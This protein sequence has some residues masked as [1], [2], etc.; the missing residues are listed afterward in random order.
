MLISDLSIAAFIATLFCSF[1]FLLK[2]HNLSVVPP[3]VLLCVVLV[4]QTL[5]SYI[6]LHPEQLHLKSGAILLESCL[7]FAALLYSAKFCRPDGFAGLS[8]TSQIL[9]P[10]ALLFALSG[11]WLRSVPLFFSPDFGDEKVLFLTNTGFT[12][13]LLLSVFLVLSMM[14]LERTLSAL[15]Q[16]ERWRVKCEI[17]AFCVLLGTHVV[18]FSQAFLYRSLD[19]RLLDVRSFALLLTVVLLFYSRV[20]RSRGVEISISRGVAYRS[21]ILF[22]VGV[23]ILGLGLLGEGLEYISFPMQRTFLLVVAMV[24]A[25]VLSLLFLSENV[26]RKVKAVVHRNFFQSKFDYRVHWLAFTDR[27]ST[28]ATLPGLQQEIL[29]FFCETF[30]CKGAALYLVQPD[31]QG[32]FRVALLEFPVDR[33]IFSDTDPLLEVLAEKD[34]IVNLTEP[35]K[36]LEGMLFE[37]MGAVGASFIIPLRFDNEL[38]GFI[39]LAEQINKNEL[40]TYE[41]YDLMR[42]LAR[43][44]IATLQ[45][46]TL[47][48]QLTT[49]RELAAIGKV[50]TFVLHDLKNQ[51]SGLSMMLDNAREYIEDPEFQQD[52]LETVGNTVGNMKGLIARLKN[53]KDKPQLITAPADLQNIIANA[54]RACGGKVQVAGKTRLI[55]VDEEEIYK[56]VLNLLVNAHEAS[57]DSEEIKINFGFDTD[58]AFVRVT[59]NGC[60]MSADFIT[61]DLF[62]PFITTKNHGFGIGLYQCRQIAEAHQG[63]IEVTSLPGKG[64]VFTLYLPLA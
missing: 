15:N 2:F 51:V 55:D 60:G 41:D 9:L 32:F 57:T 45:G 5:E 1:Y 54:V 46:V 52:M 7:P 14:Q 11:L 64:S 37:T 33:R 8:R 38:A 34:F 17:V 49:A 48:E 24:S 20:Y 16:L 21:F 40:L 3:L 42:L 13:Y 30:G 18:Y 27:I 4:L 12:F 58:W 62:K 61:N 29:M 28:A 53:L 39:V 59:D 19:M 50:S 31:E 56:L 6:L 35:N 43:Q 22:V 25:V 23:Y 47:S 26:Q 36:G 63:K 44:S 10:S